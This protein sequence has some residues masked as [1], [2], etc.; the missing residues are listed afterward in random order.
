[1]SQNLYCNLPSPRYY[2]ITLSLSKKEKRKD[3]WKSSGFQFYNL[4]YLNADSWQ[5]GLGNAHPPH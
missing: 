5:N 2:K 1:M 3:A 4:F